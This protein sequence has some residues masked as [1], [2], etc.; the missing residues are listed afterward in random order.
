MLVGRVFTGISIVL[1]GLGLLASVTDVPAP[2]RLDSVS[3]DSMYVGAVEN[4]GDCEL[5]TA[6]ACKSY[7]HTGI[8]AAQYDGVTRTTCS[9][10][11]NEYCNT[12]WWWHDCVQSPGESELKDCPAGT[13]STCKFAFT[14]TGSQWTFVV[15]NANTACGKKGVCTSGD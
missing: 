15:A 14:A 11:H 4:D 10:S 8:C 2:D 13:T 7:G 6:V 9:S 5:D 12:S 1:L 3:E